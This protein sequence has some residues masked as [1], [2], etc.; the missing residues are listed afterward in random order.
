MSN[1]SKIPSLNQAEAE[2]F[3]E[4]DEITTGVMTSLDE[5]AHDAANSV[6][7]EVEQWLCRGMAIVQEL[8]THVLATAGTSPS[9]SAPISCGRW[10]RSRRAW[11][12]MLRQ[13]RS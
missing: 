1:L 2:F 3:R 9:A 10:M 8:T 13:S 5:I 12:R 6:S 11:T 4:M 7:P